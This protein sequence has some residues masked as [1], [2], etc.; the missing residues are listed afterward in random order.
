[1]HQCGLQYTKRVLL[2]AMLMDGALARQAETGLLKATIPPNALVGSACT[3]SRYA[4]LRSDLLAMPQGFVCFTMT[5]VG[6]AKS[7]TVL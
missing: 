3:A 7:Q 1:M 4:S 5:Q 6:S 2:E